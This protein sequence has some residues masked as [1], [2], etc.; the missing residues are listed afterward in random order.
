MVLYGRFYTILICSGLLIHIYI[1]S[2]DTGLFLKEKRLLG[3]KIKA[4]RAV[5]WELKGVVLFCYIFNT[6]AINFFYIMYM[7]VGLYLAVKAMNNDWIGKCL[8]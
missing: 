4:L 6:S 3:I 2:Y 8:R 1:L 7:R 5:L